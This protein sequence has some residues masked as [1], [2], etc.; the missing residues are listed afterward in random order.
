MNTQAHLGTYLYTYAGGPTYRV[1]CAT[2]H[3]LHW[4]CL[5]GD[6]KG[7]SAHEKPDRVVVAPGIHFLSWVET[8]G[9]IVTQVLNYAAHTV[10]CT[11]VAGGERYLL[12]GKL[13]RTA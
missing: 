9:T 3:D 10:T 6:D 2:D 4:E 11:V 8:S 1:T 5:K 12:Q 7:Q 13:E